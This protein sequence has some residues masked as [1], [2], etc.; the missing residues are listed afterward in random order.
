MSAILTDKKQD[1]ASLELLY[2]ISRE[3]AAQLDLRELLERVLQLTLE[4]VGAHSGSIIV[5]DEEDALI[6]GAVAYNGVLLNHSDVKLDAA[7]ERGLAGWVFKNRQAAS[8]PSTHED[9]RWLRQEGNEF[10]AETRSAISVP[11]VARDRIVGVMTM[12]H[13]ETGYFGEE[14][15]TLLQTIGD[16][17]G[18][19]VENARLFTAEQERR[20][21]ASTLQEIARTINSTLDPALVFPQILEQLE[22]LVD[23]NSASIYIVE[24]DQLRLVAAR[25]YEETEALLDL[26]IPLDPELLLGRVVKTGKP[27]VID[28]VQRDERWTQIDEL[29]ETQRIRG[30]IGAPLIVRELAVGLINLGSLSVGAYSSAEVEVVSAFAD[31]AAVA[32]ANAKLY[33]EAQ[34]KVKA[35]VALAE[36]AQVIT[37][38]LNLD[39]VLDRILQQTMDCMDVEA[40]SLALIDEA[41]GDLEF[42]VAKG[43]RAS[44]VVGIRLKK[45]EGI[46]GWVAEHNEPLLVANV[47]ADQRFSSKVDEQV[48]FETRVVAAAPIQVK[49]K[50]IGVLEAVNPRHSEISEEQTELL[51]GIAAQAGTAIAHAQLFAEIQ[52]AQ[53]RYAGLFED[54]IDPIL[55]TD[56][57]GKITDAN[58]RAE[59]FLGYPRKELLG[60]SVLKLHL[61]DYEQLPDD[62]SLLKAGQTVSYDTQANHHQGHILAIEV[63]AKRIDIGQLP[64]LQWILRDISER[65]ELDELRADLTSMIFHD[66]RSPLGNIISS[67]E[68]ME[69][70]ISETDE[71]LHSVVSIAQRSSRRASRLVESLLDLDRLEAGQAVLEM[72]D[73]SIGSLIA[74]AV[75]EVHPTAE[76]KGHVLQ[77]DLAKRLPHITMDVDMIRRVLINLLENAI[78]YTRSGGRIT[79]ATHKTDDELV[80]SVKDSGI[81]IPADD[82]QR[83]FDKFIGINQV[84]RRKSRGIGLAFCRLAVEAHGG[85]IWV[86][87]EEERGSTFLFTLPI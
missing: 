32:V 71:A 45:G 4:K 36:T 60:E 81:G 86:E 40:A 12:V 19:V 16:Q 56:L 25:G 11:L 27:I 18:I 48:G 85:R 17:A 7:F 70:S 28:D 43:E 77:F 29:Q 3:L 42:K 41:S 57:K 87:S 47:Q 53:L 82:R 30:W 58:H 20:R 75:E 6:D 13:H 76:A 83:I 55:I 72:S 35:M 34:R 79:M 61:P 84:S 15:M 23:F 50:T 63:H 59:T 14:E 1:R 52:T 65:L 21:F 78:K 31:Q 38:S 9:E 8:L 49:E 62:L 22:R 33:S 68:V 73:A 24:D 26:A 67:L 10:D 74:E 64:F 69:N 80:V 51:M 5:L 54:S 44:D 66:L 46:A 39:E 2:M 37:A